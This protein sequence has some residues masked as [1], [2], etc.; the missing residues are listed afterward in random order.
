MQLRPELTSLYFG[1]FVALVFLVCLNMFIGVVSRSFW[2]VH[3]DAT[4]ADRWKIAARH[5]E[6]DVVRYLHRKVWKA[7][8]VCLRVCTRKHKPSVATSSAEVVGD[9]RRPS[10]LARRLSQIES[11]FLRSDADTVE[12]EVRC[13]WNPSRSGL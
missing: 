1:L 7:V 8:E 6:A 5:A 4:T 11:P 13:L 10:A 9:S 3:K 2:E 12:L